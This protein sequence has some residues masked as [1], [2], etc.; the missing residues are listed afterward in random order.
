MKKVFLILTTTLAL[1]LTACGSSA[2]PTAIATVSLD[3]A[4]QPSS[5]SGNASASAVV[6]PMQK[7]EL[8]FPT[9]GAVKTVEVAEGDSVTANQPLVT[10]DTSILESRIKEAESNVIIA[11]TNVTYLKRSG[12]TP[13]RLD[14]AL[15]DVQRA[16][17]AV[18]IAK[19]SS[20]RPHAAPFD[21]TIASVE[22]SPAEIANPARSS[23]RWATFQNSRLKP[24][25]SAKKCDLR[26]R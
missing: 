7:V 18:D 22:I 25:T 1:V 11:Q 26:C 19:R 6:V 14:A 8:A 4:S 3:S 2:T 9:L 10:L 21:G 13:E 23:L 16:Q 12:T 24:P 15:A 5:S 20:H 17:A